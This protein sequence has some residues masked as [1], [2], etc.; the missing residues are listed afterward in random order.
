MK[1][2]LTTALVLLAM[3]GCS[4]SHPFAKLHHDGKHDENVYEEHIFYT[5]YLNPQASQLD[6]HIQRDLDQLRTNPD[7]PIVHNDLG[8]ALVQKG[9]PKDAEREFERAVSNDKTYYPAWYNLG[10]VRQSRGE[11]AGAETAYLQA[12]RYRPGHALALFQLGLL[13]EHSGRTSE[14]IDYYAKAFLINHQLLDIRVNPRILDS[15]IVDLAMIKAYPDQHARDSMQF[16]GAPTGYADNP[17]T[18]PLP[19]PAATTT[20]APAPGTVKKP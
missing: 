14:A 4:N 2:P 9:F 11:S 1:N 18:P 8:Q 15:K 12:V 7:Q 6:A 17:A 16:Q 20:A 3:A 13:A 10:L 19:Q 5:K